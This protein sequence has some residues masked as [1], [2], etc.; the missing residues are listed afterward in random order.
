LN[1]NLYI[2]ELA[3]VALLNKYLTNNGVITVDTQGVKFIAYN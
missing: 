2:Y 1:E 3:C